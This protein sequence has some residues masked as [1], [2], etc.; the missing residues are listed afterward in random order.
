MGQGKAWAAKQEPATLGHDR[1]R[2]ISILQKTLLENFILTQLNGAAS[3]FT[4]A[5]KA[6]DV[7]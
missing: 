5:D 2:K 3:S 7:M 4:A 6:G 1:E